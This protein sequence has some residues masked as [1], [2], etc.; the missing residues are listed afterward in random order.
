MDET[1]GPIKGPKALNGTNGAANGVNGSYA[2]NGVNGHAKKPSVNGH[3]VA[4]PR[5][6][7]T[8]KPGRG[9][10]AW[11]FSVLAR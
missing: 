7:S 5:R 2:V 6:R 4:P 11:S 9:F 3:A 8:P 10:I 1:N